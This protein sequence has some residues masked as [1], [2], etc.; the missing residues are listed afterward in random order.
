MN[1]KDGIS[2]EL[3]GLIKKQEILVQDIDRVYTE[4]FDKIKKRKL[5]IREK[6]SS[7][8]VQLERIYRSKIDQI[9]QQIFD[10][11]KVDKLK[12]EVKGMT[13]V[14]LLRSVKSSMSMIEKA[15]T[16]PSISVSKKPNKI[17]KKEEDMVELSKLIL[18]LSNSEIKSRSQAT[19]NTKGY[20][21][22]P[23][24]TNK[25][26]PFLNK[27]YSREVLNGRGKLNKPTFGTNKKS[28]GNITTAY[29]DIRSDD[30]IPVSLGVKKRKA[31]KGYKSPTDRKLKSLRCVKESE[32]N[33]TTAGKLSK[34]IM[35]FI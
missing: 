25:N 17:Y 10:V 34:V 2:D 14:Q 31:Q 8:F 23:S 5:E 15:A 24:G 1:L 29:I 6:V 27:C 26:K 7:E 11:D 13:Q 28:T 18:R 9:D 20:S 16:L 4:I 35:M 19:Y 21:S 22:K 12:N 30:E 33:K 32:L 3:K